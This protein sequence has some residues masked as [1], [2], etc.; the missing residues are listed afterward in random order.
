LARAGQGRQ[1]HFPRKYRWLDLLA[2]YQG[3]IGHELFICSRLTGKFLGLDKVT[4]LADKV[5]FDQ[6]FIIV[7]RPH[8]TFS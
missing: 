4:C 3:R 8:H 1:P 5:G 6:K 7:D 2:G